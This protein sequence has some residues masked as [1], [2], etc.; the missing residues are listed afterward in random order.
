MFSDPINYLI[1]AVIKNLAGTSIIESNI[2]ALGLFLFRI[3]F[4]IIV[5]IFVDMIVR[6]IK[7]KIVYRKV[8]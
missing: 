1:L 5:A 2:G 6:S 4:T 8:R 7:G 3:L